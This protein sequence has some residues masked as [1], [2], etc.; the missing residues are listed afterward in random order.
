MWKKNQIQFYFE[1]CQAIPFGAA[2]PSSLE[3][4]DSL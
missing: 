1:L 3:F 4:F 2:S